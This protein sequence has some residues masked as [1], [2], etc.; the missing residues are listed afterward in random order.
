M[1]RKTGSGAAVL[2]LGLSLH[3]L[4]QADMSFLPRCDKN[5]L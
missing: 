4:L 3:G 2:Y 1:D 5:Q